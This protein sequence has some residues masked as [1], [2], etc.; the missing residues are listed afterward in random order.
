MQRKIVTLALFF[1]F[2]TL[3]TA[4]GLR[5]YAQMTSTFPFT[6][7]SSSLVDCW[8]F[9]ASF[10]ATQ[11]QNFIVQ[12][13]ENPSDIGLVSL[14][15][16]IVPQ[17]S[18]HQPWLCDDGPVYL[19]WNEGAYVTANWVAPSAGAYAVLL[20]NYSYKSV[21]GVISVTAPNAT[22]SAN[23]IGPSMV[24]RII[25]IGPSCTGS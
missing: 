21:S 23:P 14:D 15:F 1:V 9:G 6:L 4:P 25:C 11:G 16:Y 19:Y 12:W 7:P 20:V 17:R 22:L 10:Y 3:G 2:L 13:R 8:Y 18:V 24:R 5:A